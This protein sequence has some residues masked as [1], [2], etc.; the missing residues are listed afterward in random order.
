MPKHWT[1]MPRFSICFSLYGF[2]LQECPFRTF[3]IRGLLLR[4]P[5]SAGKKGK[6]LIHEFRRKKF[7]LHKLYC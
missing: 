1:N 4:N 3:F 2:V 6:S 5:M 7:G